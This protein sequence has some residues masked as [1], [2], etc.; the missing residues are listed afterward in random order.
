MGSKVEG[1]NGVRVEGWG[2]RSR[3]VTGLGLRVGVGV[4]QGRDTA[5]LTERSAFSNFMVRV[6]CCHTLGETGR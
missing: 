2:Q 6:R 3:V 5:A 4:S 1:C